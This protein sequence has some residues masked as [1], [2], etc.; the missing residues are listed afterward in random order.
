M[1]N[2]YLEIRSHEKIFFI[3]N[4]KFTLIVILTNFF[5]KKIMSYPKYAYVRKNIK[6]GNI[7]YALII[8]GILLQ[9]W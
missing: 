7:T 5:L 9:T 6:Y 3:K 1:N 4:T 2:Y 8:L